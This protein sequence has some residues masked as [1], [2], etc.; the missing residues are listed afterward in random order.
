MEDYIKNH[1]VIHQCLERFKEEFF[2]VIRRKELCRVNLKDF[3]TANQ[4]PIE[5]INKNSLYRDPQMLLDASAISKEDLRLANVPLTRREEEVL[6]WYVKG[7]TAEE[8]GKRI[9]LSGRTVEDYFERIK[10]KLGSKQRSEI[11]EISKKLKLMGII[12]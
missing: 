8:I 10:Y 4:S 9:F 3:A 12:S 2:P 6:G 11:F 1:E 5:I 7:L